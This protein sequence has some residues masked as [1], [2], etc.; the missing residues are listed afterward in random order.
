MPPAVRLDLELDP[1]RP[2]ERLWLDPRRNPEAWLLGVRVESLD[3]TG[4]WRELAGGLLPRIVPVVA[5][6]GRAL[7]P[8]RPRKVVVQRLRLITLGNH[9]P[10]VGLDGFALE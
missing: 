2:L 4:A 1:A 6:P 9:S 8:I 5:A 10:N 7:C 3:M